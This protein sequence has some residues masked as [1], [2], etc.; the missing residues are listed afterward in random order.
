MSLLHELVSKVGR[1]AVLVNP[2]AATTTE[3]TLQGVQDAARAIGLQI[4]VLNA[5]TSREIDAAFA[6]LQ[7]EDLDGL[8]VAPDSF[9]SGAIAQQT[10]TKSRE[11]FRA[12]PHASGRLE[13][14]RTCSSETN[15]K[16]PRSRTWF[17]PSSRPSPAS[18]VHVSWWSGPSC[19]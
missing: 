11:D 17:A 19:G 2:A 3:I 14:I 10:A 15:G 13:Q 16:G 1:V 18:L 9:F 7:R 4:H 6:T 8:F 12:Y 5:S